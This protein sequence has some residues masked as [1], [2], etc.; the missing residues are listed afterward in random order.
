MFDVKLT[1]QKSNPYSRELNNQ[2]IIE[3]AKLGILNPEMF[4]VNLP[5]LNALQF[6]GKDAII[7]DLR[8]VSDKLKSAAQEQQQA[9]IQSQMQTSS[10]APEGMTPGMDMAMPPAGGEDLV[11]VTEMLQM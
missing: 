2:T 8:E 9:L 1:V 7:K 6:D 4:E 5:V 3:L 10:G 11:D